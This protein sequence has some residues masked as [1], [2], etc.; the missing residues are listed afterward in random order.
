MTFPIT[1][2]KAIEIDSFIAVAITSLGI[3]IPSQSNDVARLIHLWEF[4]SF[5][6][7]LYILLDVRSHF[8]CSFCRLALQN[9]VEST[10]TYTP[11]VNVSGT[12]ILKRQITCILRALENYLSLVFSGHHVQVGLL[13]TVGWH[14]FYLVVKFIVNIFGQ[15]GSRDMGK[16]TNF[17]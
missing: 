11:R 12:S 15:S 6:A 13:W 10:R 16:P 3:L 17:R 7:N 2:L 4:C 9:K 1:F 8:H 14:F 5:R